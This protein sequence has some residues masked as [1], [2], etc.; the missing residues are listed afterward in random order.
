[1]RERWKNEKG[2]LKVLNNTNKNQLKRLAEN[3]DVPF[4]VICDSGDVEFLSQDNFISE[5]SEQ[6]LKARISDVFI[7]GF[8]ENAE[9]VFFCCGEY[10]FHELAIGDDESYFIF[11]HLDNIGGADQARKFLKLAA[12]AF[13]C[14]EQQSTK[15]FMQLFRKLLIGGKNSVSCRQIYETYGDHIREESLFTVLLVSKVNADNKYSGD[16]ND[17]GIALQSVF[18][19]DRGFIVVNIDNDHT[20]VICTVDKENTYEDV[21]QYADTIHDTMISEA[22]TDVYVSAGSAVDDIMNVS[23]SYE[24]AV[25]ATSIG[26]VFNIKSK[27]FVYPRLGLEKMIYSIPKESARAYISELFGETFL[28]DKSSKELLNTVHVFLMNNLNVSEASR[29]LYIHRNTLMYR[30]DKFNKMTKLDCTKF[31]TGM[32]IAVAMR[33]LQYLER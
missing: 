16:D 7:A 18:S 14:G 27:C 24:E 11:V 13:L 9:A 30:L 32:Q 8:T 31:A 19:V 17:I 2:G 25:K 3:V 5:E 22:L 12:F 29:A 1:M 6:A 33:I 4:G 20:A 15:N 23:V 21:L 26:E 28:R 10:G